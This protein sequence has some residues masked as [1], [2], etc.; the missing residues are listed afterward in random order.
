[1]KFKLC[2]SRLMLDIIYAHVRVDD[3]DLGFEN[4]CKAHPRFLLQSISS[5]DLMI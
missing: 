3:L 1:M 2:T 5:V 4:V